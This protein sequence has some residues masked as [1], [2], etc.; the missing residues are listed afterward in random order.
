M[1]NRRI[2]IFV[3]LPFRSLDQLTLQRKL[4]D[5]GNVGEAVGLT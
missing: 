4:R 5:I 3:S 2:G 1:L